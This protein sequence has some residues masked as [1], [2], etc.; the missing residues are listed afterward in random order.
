MS[1][2]S[3]AYSV[4]VAYFARWPL[5]MYYKVP[6]ITAMLPVHNVIFFSLVQETVDKQ[7]AAGVQ[8]R[9]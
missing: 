9:H 8:P 1:S 6:I 3:C 7:R 4:P 2:M 5:F